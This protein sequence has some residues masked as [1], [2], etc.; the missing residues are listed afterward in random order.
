M[1]GSQGADTIQAEQVELQLHLVKSMLEGLIQQAKIHTGAK[2]YLVKKLTLKNRTTRQPSML[3]GQAAL[4][5][6]KEHSNPF[7]SPL[8]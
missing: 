5:L 8:P 2:K 6:F 1:Y 3:D 7:G 4:S